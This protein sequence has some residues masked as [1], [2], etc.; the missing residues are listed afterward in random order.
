MRVQQ[1]PGT[2]FPT[3]DHEVDQ[4]I[5]ALFQRAG[6]TTER[7]TPK[8][9]DAIRKEL[10]KWFNAKYSVNAILIALDRLPTGEK[11]EPRRREDVVTYIRTRMQ[12]WY[13][14]DNEDSPLAEAMHKPPRPGM[15]LAQ[16]WILRQ[17][18]AANSDV[19]K[20]AAPLSERGREAREATMQQS[21]APRR[22][23]I[24][25]SRAKD[26][27]IAEAMDSLLLPGAVAPT[28]EDAQS[29]LP[30][31]QRVTSRQVAVYAGQRSVI[32]N[33]PKVRRIVERAVAEKRSLTPSETA[34]LRNAV[35]D[36]K[37]RA[38]IGALEAM[39]SET[40]HDTEILSDAAWQILSYLERA[41]APYMSLEGMVNLLDTQV[42][43]SS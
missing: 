17:R 15:S 9:R 8:D 13:D 43:E 39:Q 41:M 34:V 24:A 37:A 40:A 31:S 2:V 12:A 16:W 19:S 18:N 6:W 3:E 33:D 35:R 36:A 14:D 23:P 1:W 30:A 22:D 4:A 26:Q 32:A 42:R 28:F 5:G 38:A 25:R 29:L 7:L 21:R 10:V 20:S 27:A 11:Q